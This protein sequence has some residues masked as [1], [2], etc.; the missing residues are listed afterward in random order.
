MYEKCRIWLWYVITWWVNCNKDKKK[1][2][3]HLW[4]NEIFLN[5]NLIYV[6]YPDVI[7]ALLIHNGPAKS[8]MDRQ[9]LN[10][11]AVITLL[12]W[13]H[14]KTHRRILSSVATSLHFQSPVLFR[15]TNIIKKET[16]LYVIVLHIVAV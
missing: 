9:S 4:I 14:P 3:T 10:G 5:I 12:Y 16:K 1:K 2:K 11:P 8:V 7:M 6:S 13:Q 15:A